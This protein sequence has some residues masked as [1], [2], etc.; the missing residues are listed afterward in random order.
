[1]AEDHI[2]A[3]WGNPLDQLGRTGKGLDHK[4]EHQSIGRK[5]FIDRSAVQFEVCG[6]SR[7]L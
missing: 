4:G 2:N 7:I 6:R 5:S 1:M 3:Q